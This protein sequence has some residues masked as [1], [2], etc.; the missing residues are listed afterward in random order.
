MGEVMAHG[1]LQVTTLP[2][3]GGMAAFNCSFH[4]ISIEKYNF[5]SLKSLLRAFGLAAKL[6]VKCKIENTS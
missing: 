4:I 3:P 1:D 5:N 2:S 6:N